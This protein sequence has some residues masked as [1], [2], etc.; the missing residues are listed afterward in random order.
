VS[1][2]TDANCQAA[3]ELEHAQICYA[4]DL[5]FPSGHVRLHTAL[6]D[7]TIVGNTF[8]GVGGL[9]SIQGT[10][11]RAK[12]QSERWTYGI[13]GVDPS[14]V[15]ESEI[16]NCFGRSVIEYEVWYTPAT[17]AVIGY[18]INREGRMGRCRRTHGGP[19]PVIQVS[20][21]NRLV[22][23]DQADAW[24]WTDE[25][26]QQFFTGDLGCDQTKNLDSKEVLW[27]GSRVNPGYYYRGPGSPNPT[28]GG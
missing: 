7:L 24:R 14:V 11:D 3:A 9:G 22:I 20:C 4:V 28:R 15:P 21:D 6:G 5:D 27:G 8:T 19:N 26:Q 12:L 1:W 2:F 17:Q 23:L 16:D 10:P 18:E 13:A 25:H